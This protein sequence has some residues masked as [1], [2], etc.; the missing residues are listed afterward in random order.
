M[1]KTDFEITKAEAFEIGRLEGLKE[2]FK[3]ML[4]LSATDMVFY[5]VYLKARLKSLNDNIL[6][7]EKFKKSLSHKGE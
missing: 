5:K 7:V 3:E 4:D 6:N 2:A 1:R